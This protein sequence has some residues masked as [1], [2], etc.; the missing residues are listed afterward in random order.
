VT[1]FVLALFAFSSGQMPQDG[2]VPP[3]CLAPS[4]IIR[5]EA[6]VPGSDSMRRRL[7]VRPDGTVFFSP[8][9]AV[10]VAGLTSAEAARQIRDW[11]AMRGE[12]PSDKISVRV[13]VVTFRTP[14]IWVITH[15]DGQEQKLYARRLTGSE[16]VLDAIASVNG[17]PARCSKY[18]IW[19]ERRA[20]GQAAG[21][22]GLL[23][24]WLGITQKGN[25]ATNYSLQDGDRVYVGPA[26]AS[27]RQP[28]ALDGLENLHFWTPLR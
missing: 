27:P 17:L 9:G 1:G 18:R 14:H 11:L 4:D 19:V 6:S 7:L 25:T 8:N 16:T 24:D 21:P 3:D 22:E 15:L 10:Y 2:A 5:V 12:C 20:G 26:P 28:S 23:V 13:G